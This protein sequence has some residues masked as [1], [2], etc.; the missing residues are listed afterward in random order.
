MRQDQDTNPFEEELGTVLHRAGDS[1]GAVTVPDLASGGLSR[2]RRRLARRR[3]AA[4]GGSVLALALVGTAGAYG[5]G[6]FGGNGPDEVTERSSVG[7]AAPGETAEK[8]PLDARI[9]V[10][11]LAAV[12]KA[13]TP[14][15][16]WTIDNSG[17]MGQA[18]SG[19]Y[20]D[21]KG[22]AAVSLGLYRAG[23]TDESGRGQVTCPSRTAVP[24]DDCTSTVVPG[25]G[26]LMVLQGYE[27]PDRRKDTKSW[28][29]VLLTHDGFLIDAS[30][31]NSPAQK[32]AG[33]SRTDPPFSPAQLK[34][35][36][37]AD[38]WRPLLKQLPALP[39]PDRGGAGQAQPPAEPSAR[40]VQA[41]LRSL[42]PK[43]L[44]VVSEHGQAG[45]GSLVVDDGKGNSLIGINVQPDMRDVAHQ[46]FTGSGVQTLPDG[47]R[48]KLEKKPGEKGGEGVV[49]WTADTMRPDGFRV[50][51]SAFNTG[52]QHEPAT[53]TNPALTLEQ[54]KAI[55]LSPKWQKLSRTTQR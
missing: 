28:R 43:G 21:G 25:G 15:G 50:V 5:G 26:R 2:G 40:D 47:T 44:G 3:A 33:T 37:T 14:A 18:V 38:G 10:E 27:Y 16:S 30:E 8:S 35:L 11:D 20:D 23:N 51:V 12:L 1:F 52:A 31:W 32:G 46:L 13:N 17:G 19:V 36:V 49:W 7:A 54:L 34:A 42:L 48:V 4:V 53:R 9:P 55:A 45:Y 39:E 22:K 41:T 6:L 24:Y 29:A